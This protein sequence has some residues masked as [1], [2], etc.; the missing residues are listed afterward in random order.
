STWSDSM[1]SHSGDPVALSIIMALIILGGIGFIVV[2]DLRHAWKGRRNITPYKLTLHTKIVL[3]TSLLLTLV[4]WALFTMFEW[5][6]SFAGMGTID[7]FVN[8]L[9]MSVTA[10]TAGFNTVDY[11]AASDSS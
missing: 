6:V 10:R 3:A 11:G 5:N 8:G 7:R 4:G 1:M 9:F 2:T